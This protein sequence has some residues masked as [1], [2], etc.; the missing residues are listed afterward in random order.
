MLLSSVGSIEYMFTITFFV[1]YYLMLEVLVL[2][3]FQNSFI[4]ILIAPIIVVILM[5]LE[6]IGEGYD[7]Y[8][9]FMFILLA[10]A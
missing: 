8:F 4:S 1:G 2:L 6:L 7:T 10:I 3:H 5:F 9:K